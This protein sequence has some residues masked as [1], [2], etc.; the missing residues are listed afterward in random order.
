MIWFTFPTFSFVVRWSGLH[1]RHFDLSWDDLV[2]IADIFICREMIW[3]TLPTFSFVVRWS[4]LHCR[5]FHLSWDG[6]VYI[7]DIFFRTVTSNYNINPFL[8]T[9]LLIPP[10]N[11]RKPE[12]FWCFQG[13][14]KEISGMKWVK[15]LTNCRFRQFF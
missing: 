4:G 7:A 14:S 1:Y 6:L 13:V 5:H 9:D 3:F 15:G 10:E 2:Y 12:V 8:A 11:I